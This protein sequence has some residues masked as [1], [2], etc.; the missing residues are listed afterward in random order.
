M[1]NPSLPS[2]IDCIQLFIER[3][4]VQNNHLLWNILTYSKKKQFKFQIMQFSWNEFQIFS[5]NNVQNPS[6]RDDQLSI[7][8]LNI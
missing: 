6:Y 8:K 3:E 7:K 1:R 2:Q 4:K 5:S